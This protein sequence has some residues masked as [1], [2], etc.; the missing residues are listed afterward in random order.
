MTDRAIRGLLIALVAVVLA[1]TPALAQEWVGQGRVKVIVKDHNGKPVADAQIRLRLMRAPEIRPDKDFR[2]DKKGK[3]S[4][5]GLKGGT[6]V[7]MVV[8]D[9][10]E[11]WE[12]RVEIYSAG[13][14]ETYKVNL[15]PLPEEVI[16]AQKQ[17]K[18]YDI[19]K[20]GDALL[21][22]GDFV[23]ARKEYEK[24][25]GPLP[26][27]DKPI[28]LAAI[29]NT[30]IS[31]GN[32]A[33]ARPALE[34]A[35]AIDPNHVGSLKGM[36]AIIAS[37]GDMEGAEAMLAR[38]PEDEPVHPNTLMNIGMSRYNKG[39]MDKALPFI[40]RT[41]RDFPDTALAYYFR[42]LIA[43]SQGEQEQPR[44]DFEKFLE[45]EPEHPQAAEAREYLSYLPAESGGE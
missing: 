12:D 40:E 34:K 42:G 16:Q 9:G 39:E 30:H 18:A 27:K 25:L 35:L 29:A 3:F 36:C 37:E 8:A 17:A 1:T 19:A 26:E 24:A 45:L 41:I 5:L 38:I 11:P 31:E 15:T 4:Y 13:A 23:G 28:L 10:F 43:L 22:K 20:A 33:A 6:W 14:P 7:M 2:T 32:P 21:A 44:A